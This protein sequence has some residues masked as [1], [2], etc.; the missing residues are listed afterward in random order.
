MIERNRNRAGRVWCVVQGAA[1][2]VDGIVRVASL[3]FLHTRLPLIASREA[4]LAA[5]KLR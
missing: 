1:E 4:A 2:I 3:G 5:A